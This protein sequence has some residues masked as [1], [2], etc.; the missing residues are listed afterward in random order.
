MSDTGEQAWRRVAR[1]TAAHQRRRPRASSR[2]RAAWIAGALTIVLSFGI[3]L[4]LTRPAKPPTPAVAAMTRSIVSDRR[5]LMAAVK[6]AGLSGSQTVRGAL[7]DITRL[8]DSRVSVSGWAGE[9]GNGA[10]PLHVV[11]FADGEHKLTMQTE[12]QHADITAALGLADAVAARNVS[13]RGTVP[14]RRG[15]PLVIVAVADSGNYG[16]FSPRACP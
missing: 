3:T 11:V 16:Y 14:C 5:S 6:A 12:G 7:D 2:P 15:Q 1:T 13:F 10:A 4:Q 9:V 8:D